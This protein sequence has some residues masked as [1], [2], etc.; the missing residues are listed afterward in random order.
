MKKG[1]TLLE[2]VVTIAI[3]G[4]LLTIVVF[5]VRK[6]LV[7]SRDSKREINMEQIVLS[8]NMFYREYG[9]MPITYGT[10]CSPAIDYFQDDLNSGWDYSSIG[11]GFMTFLEDAGFEPV[12][13]DPLN[14][15]TG[16]ASPSGTYAYRY[17]CYTPD[18]WPTEVDEPLGV[19]LDYWKE[20]EVWEEESPIHIL[21]PVQSPDVPEFPCS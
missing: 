19:A 3:V 4:I 13:L 17:Y 14:N 10:A 15:M 21:T 7:N 5:S 20:G 6:T 16:D 8:L 9:C 18:D 11:G 12:A 1:F 2:I